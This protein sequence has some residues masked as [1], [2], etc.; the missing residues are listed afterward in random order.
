MEK[1][2]VKICAGTTCFVM[3]GSELL[4]LP[5]LLDDDLK[6]RVQ[7]EGIN[8]FGECKNSGCERAPFVTINGNLYTNVTLSSLLEEVKKYAEH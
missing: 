5:D 2:Q 3:G 7:I 1:I 8:C 6:D 4:L